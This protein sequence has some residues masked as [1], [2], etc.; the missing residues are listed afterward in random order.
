MGLNK[1]EWRAG[2]LSPDHRYPSKLVLTEDVEVFGLHEPLS[3]PAGTVVVFTGESEP[4]VFAVRGPD[5][6]SVR[7]PARLLKKA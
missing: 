6:R 3:W 1:F 5:G 7:L 2:G 4:A